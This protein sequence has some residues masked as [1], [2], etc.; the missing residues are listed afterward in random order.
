MTRF[1]TRFFHQHLISKLSIVEQVWPND[2]I[3]HWTFL[4]TFQLLIFLQ[5]ISAKYIYHHKYLP[6]Q[7]D[8]IAH[9]FTRLPRQGCQTSRFSC[10]YN[11]FARFFD[12]DQ[13][14]LNTTRLHSTHSTRWPNGSIFPSPFRRV[15]IF[16]SPFR[17]VE[18]QVVWPK[19]N[20]SSS[21][22]IVFHFIFIILF[23]HTIHFN[24]KATK[25][26]N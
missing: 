13:T 12:K 4:S 17:R 18:N 26:T 15:S 3:F 1:F 16:P 25:V 5:R 24:L 10:S 11:Y 22:F 14:S 7:G 23:I 9:A 20:V 19:P 2:S 8:A 6:A 21:G